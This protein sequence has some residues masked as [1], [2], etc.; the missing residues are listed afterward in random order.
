MLCTFRFIL[1]VGLA[2]YQS[3]NFVLRFAYLSFHV[4]VAPAPL[5]LCYVPGFDL[6]N[7]PTT[8]P[9]ER[10]V[11]NEFY[12]A[13]KG[14]EWTESDKWTLQQNDH[15]SWYGVTCN[16][17]FV[18]ELILRSN[19][20][21]GKLDSRISELSFLEVL[22]L[23][24]NDIKVCVSSYFVGLCLGLLLC[25]IQL[26]TWH[27]SCVAFLQ[28][29]SSFLGQYSVGNW[30]STQSKIFAALLQFFCRLCSGRA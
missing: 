29:V 6:R 12:Y 1:L 18:T 23:S 19:G 5:D 3:A 2:D 8:C 22:D 25:I 20:L 21:S 15:C 27:V 4:R 14:R 9:P 11:L 24:D 30:T 10:Y 26:Q 28:S 7:D 13:A 17:G 16:K